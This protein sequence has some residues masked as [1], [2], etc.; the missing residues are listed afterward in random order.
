MTVFISSYTNSV[1]KKGRVSVPASFRA[2]MA[3]HS[4]Q[5]VVVFAA[6]KEGYLYAWSYDDFVNFAEKIKALP[7][8]SATRQRLAR[9][10][11]AA[12]RPLGFDG[13]GRMMLPDDLLGGANIQGKAL[14]AGQGDYFTIWNP[15]AYAE[16]VAGDESNFE[17]DLEALEGDWDGFQ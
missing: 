1:D 17:K 5:T 7:P 2:E 10:I 12:A 13:E 9:T 11:L 16:K 8:M 15:D 6:P 14:F 3:A 4:R